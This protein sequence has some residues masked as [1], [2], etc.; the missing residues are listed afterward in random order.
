M[1][2]SGEI[3]APGALLPVAPGLAAPGPAA[4]EGAPA[5]AAPAT[6]PARGPKAPGPPKRRRSSA[7]SSTSGGG[8]GAGSVKSALNATGPTVATIACKLNLNAT[9]IPKR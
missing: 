7:A 2:V 1:D 6:A 5:P 8:G 4:G 3:L 9:I